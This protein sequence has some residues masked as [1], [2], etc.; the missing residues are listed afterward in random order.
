MLDSTDWEY[1]YHHRKFQWIK[2]LYLVKQ[3]T[4]VSMSSTNLGLSQALPYT[5]D[6]LSLRK[7]INFL[8]LL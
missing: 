8:L 2:L 6:N 5:T 1:F 4:Q 7:D 3:F